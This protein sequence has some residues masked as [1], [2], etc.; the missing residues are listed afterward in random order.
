MWMIRVCL[1]WNSQLWMT[2]PESELCVGTLWRFL[3]CCRP[4]TFLIH[5]LVYSQCLLTKDGLSLSFCLFQDIYLY[6][7]TQSHLSSHPG[8]VCCPG[9]IRLFRDGCMEISNMTILLLKIH[10]THFELLWNLSLEW[11]NLERVQPWNATQHS[12]W[13]ME[14]GQSMDV[15]WT[16]KRIIVWN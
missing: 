11:A 10:F 14:S 1:V 4:Q 2:L 3:T 5:P 15:K 16:D 12:A 8:Y 9:Q 13:H 6:K 7:S